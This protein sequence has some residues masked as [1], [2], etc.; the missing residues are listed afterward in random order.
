[1]R[2]S[3]NVNSSDAARGIVGY[4]DDVRPCTCGVPT[5]VLFRISG[6]EFVACSV[7]CAT[8]ISRARGE[9]DGP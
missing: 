6:R 2:V 9:S 7:E 8:E 1:M 5:N 3:R 4:T